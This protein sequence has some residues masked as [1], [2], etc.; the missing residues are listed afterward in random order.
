MEIPVSG[1]DRYA[2]IYQTQLELEA[3]WLRYGADEK[4]NSWRP[5]WIVMA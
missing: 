5:C 2:E 1:R 3:E 4:V